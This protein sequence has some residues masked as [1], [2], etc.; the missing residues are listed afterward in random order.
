MGNTC[1]ASNVPE[2]ELNDNQAPTN[3]PEH[4]GA[5]SKKPDREELAAIKI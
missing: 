2:Q 3:V 4:D 5:Q 1:C